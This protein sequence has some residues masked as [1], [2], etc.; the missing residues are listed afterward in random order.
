MQSH[1]GNG[2]GRWAILDPRNRD[3][4]ARRTLTAKRSVVWDGSTQ[5]V[6]DQ[7]DVGGCT[8]FTVADVL[9]TPM[10][11]KSRARGGKKGFLT[12]A[13]ALKFY[14][15]ATVND[16]FDGT[17]PPVDTGS[18][19][20]AAAKAAKQARFWSSYGHTFTFESFLANLQQQPVML[21]TAWTEGMSDP[22]RGVV[23]PSGEIVG[24]H[25]YMACRIDWARGMV[26]CLNHW[27]KDWGVNGRF[28]VALADM[29]WLLA[30]D[31]DVVVPKPV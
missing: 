18:T 31:G 3:F 4:D 25:E 9:N 1:V 6:L 12:N 28:W 8:G 30:Q 24:G 27:T 29:E 16:E 5:P 19:G 14:H 20:T 2:L 15:Q 13:D 17:Y 10:F 23:R 7:K 21:G 22:R 26:G 11:A